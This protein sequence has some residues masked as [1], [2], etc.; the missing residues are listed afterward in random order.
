MRHLLAAVVSISILVVAPARAAVDDAAID[1]ASKE[2]RRLFEESREAGNRPGQGDMGDYVD[3][4]F[5]QIAIDQLTLDQI[6][7]QPSF[8]APASRAPSGEKS[9]ERTPQR[10]RIAPTRSPV[11]AFQRQTVSCGPS[12][13]SRSPAG[14]HAR[15]YERTLVWKAASVDPVSRSCTTTLPS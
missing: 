12:V 8:P 13:A 3:Q 4:A 7:T 1:Q 9:S 14:D 15:Q 11:A 5:A 6:R 10:A 2:Y